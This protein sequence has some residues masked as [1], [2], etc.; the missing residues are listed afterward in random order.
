MP[1]HNSGSTYSVTITTTPTLIKGHDRE[2]RVALSLSNVSSV[3][4]YLG[5]DSNVTTSSG[6]PFEADEKRS[7]TGYHGNVY[8]VVA[9]G[10]A[11]VRV[12]WY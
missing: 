8:G 6:F 10:T 1:S 7:E 11:E 9:A 5:R 4:V 2:P 12:D 3:T